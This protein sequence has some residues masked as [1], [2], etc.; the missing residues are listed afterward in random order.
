MPSA[1]AGLLGLS[2]CRGAMGPT[3]LAF[4]GGGWGWE[5]VYQEEPLDDRMN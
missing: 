2:L 5:G 3:R 1:A 4:L